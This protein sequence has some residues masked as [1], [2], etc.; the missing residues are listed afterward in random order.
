M[1]P[2]RI[3]SVNDI[4][5]FQQ[6]SAYQIQQSSH[7]AQ[8]GPQRSLLIRCRPAVGPAWKQKYMSDAHKGDLM[9]LIG[10]LTVACGG[11]IFALTGDCLALQL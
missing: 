7:S 11:V 4:G 10:K 1:L 3:L 9:Y 8:L 5:I 2:K 6:S